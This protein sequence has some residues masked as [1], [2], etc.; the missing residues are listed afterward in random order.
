MRA[1]F[2]TFPYPPEGELLGFKAYARLAWAFR[3]R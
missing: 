2:R 1:K 3:E